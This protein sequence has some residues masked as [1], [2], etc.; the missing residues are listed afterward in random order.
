MHNLVVGKTSFRET[1][2]LDQWLRRARKIRKHANVS[3]SL[4]LYNG[5]VLV[6]KILGRVRYLGK[7][8][9]GGE[10]ES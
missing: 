10:T 5:P 2:Y 6:E 3:R 9:E 1:H 8:K 7:K 4:Q